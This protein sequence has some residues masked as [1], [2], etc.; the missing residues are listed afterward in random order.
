M[1]TQTEFTIDSMQDKKFR[2][3]KIT[4]IEMLS[5]NSQIDFTNLKS[6]QIVYSFILEHIEVNIAGVW[7]TVKEKNFDTY[8]PND[9][10]DN[11][12]ALEDLVIYFLL[13]VLKPLFTKSNE[14]NQVHR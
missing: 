13:H 14:S 6:T 1:I 5:L 12:N 7:T 3:G 11:I 8:Y 10:N 2:V 9:L 4:A